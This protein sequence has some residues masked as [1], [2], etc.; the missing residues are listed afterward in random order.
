VSEYSFFLRA[1][2]RL[3]PE[4]GQ[5]VRLRAGRGRWRGSYTAV[6][7]PY[8]DE[9]GEVV[10]RVAKEGECWAALR[11]G[12][13]SFAGTPVG[14]PWPVRQMEVVS[15][16]ASPPAGDGE[17]GTKELYREPEG[18][19]PRSWLSRIFGGA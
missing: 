12:R 1:K 4:P 7:E 3:V 5:R 13:R 18:A 9:A 2:P 14:T 8:T 19:E 16:L 17:E 10:I 11:E 15:P 6:S